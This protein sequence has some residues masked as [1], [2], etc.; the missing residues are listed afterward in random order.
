MRLNYG[1]YV[2]FIMSR[3]IF[4]CATL[5][6]DSETMMSKETERRNV[7]AAWTVAI[8]ALALSI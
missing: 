8:Q 6:G 4:E 2:S 3:N 1:A 5:A 7:W